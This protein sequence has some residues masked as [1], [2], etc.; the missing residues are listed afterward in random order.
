MGHTHIKTYKNKTWTNTIKKH[1]TKP[2]F[3]FVPRSAKEV[4]D[5][6]KSAELEGKKV[7]A[8]GSGHSFSSV[9]IVPD[10]NYLVDISRFDHVQKLNYTL[11]QDGN[12]NNKLVRV[13][14]GITI[15]A[16]NKELDQLGLSIVNMGGIDHQTISGA[17]STATHGTGIEI[18]AMHGMIRAIHLVSEDGRPMW[19]CPR[20]A[21]FKSSMQNFQ[22]VTIHRDDNDFNAC[23]VSLGAMGIIVEYILEVRHEY[24]LEESKQVELWSDVKNALKKGKRL[25]D[26]RGFMVQVNPYNGF[27]KQ[28]KSEHSCLVILHK[29]ISNEHKIKWHSKI[30]NLIGTIAGNI[31]VIRWIVYKILLQRIKYKLIKIPKSL[32]TSIKSQKDK[33]FKNTAHKVLYQGAEYVKERAYDCEVAFDIGDNSYLDI[34]DKLIDQANNDLIQKGLYLTSPIGLRFVKRS[35]AFLDPGFKRYVCYIDT[36][37]L[38][39]SVGEQEVL[40]LNLKLMVDNG[41]MPH[42]GKYNRY[43]Q[44]KIEHLSGIYKGLD[45]WKDVVVKYNTKGTFTSSF[46]EKLNLINKETLIV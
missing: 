38:L 16:F 2:Q 4:S 35:N 33:S 24:W 37:M 13:G 18:R 21:I 29:E 20:N 32:E 25:K 3:Y 1:R 15:K 34:V 7:R 43:L 42:L 5:I 14:A 44:E 28:N 11:P 17:F 30:R 6:I 46:M 12:E 36:P 8:T 41:G 40:D 27:N 45:Q 19:I 9:G 39:G 31:P 10:G 22:G 26:Q 23:S